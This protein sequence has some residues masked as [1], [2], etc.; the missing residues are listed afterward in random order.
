MR[1]GDAAISNF[2]TV[3]GD[4]HSFWAGLAS[5]SLPPSG[6]DPV[7]AA[8]I[9]GSISAAG[10]VEA[11]E[12]RFPK[13][14]PLRALY[15]ADRAGKQAASGEPAAPSRG[16]HL[17][18]VRQERGLSKRRAGLSN[19]DLAPHLRF[20][21]LGGHGYAT[22]RASYRERRNVSSLYVPRPLER[23]PTGRRR[24]IALSRSSTV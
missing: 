8:F 7:G 2:V 14:H 22:L 24:S 21:D 20:L 15:V 13:D 9:T 4:R 18:G 11:F 23:S 6:F 19:P 12:H 1:F 16:T 3:S 5:K 10:L 17:P